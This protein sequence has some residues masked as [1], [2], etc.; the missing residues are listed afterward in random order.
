[1][2]HAVLEILTRYDKS[3]ESLNN[4]INHMKNSIRFNVNITNFPSPIELTDMVM[5]KQY[6]AFRLPFPKIYFEFYDERVPNM[7]M[8]AMAH[9]VPEEKKITKETH[10]K[11]PHKTW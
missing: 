2:S 8:M 6:F 9:E 4:A 3:Q 5:D 1:M 11:I 7:K 10:S